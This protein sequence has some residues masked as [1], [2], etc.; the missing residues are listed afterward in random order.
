MC[1]ADGRSDENEM[2]VLNNE[3]AR[4]GVPRLQRITIS[5]EASK[6]EFNKAVSIISNFNS[7]QKK[8]VTAYLAIIMISDG[9]IDEKEKALWQ[10]VSLLCNLP[11][12]NL[13]EAIDFFTNL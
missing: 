1:A 12:M 6:M 5:E 2:E 4:F 11:E 13:T 7:E 3:L 9:E 8:Y 10:L